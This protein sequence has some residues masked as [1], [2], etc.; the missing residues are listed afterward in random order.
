MKS[1][2]DRRFRY[3]SAS[4]L[5]GRSAAAASASRSARRQTVRARWSRA[6]VSLP[7]GR[8]KLRSS[9]QRGVRAVAVG[10]ETVDLPPADPQPAVPLDVGHREVGPEV[11]ELVL[12]PAD[13][14]VGGADLGEAEQPS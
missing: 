6:A 7:P 14:R 3:T 8:T 4:G 12:D 5:T 1:R 2:S 9:G 13:D 11:E 10:L